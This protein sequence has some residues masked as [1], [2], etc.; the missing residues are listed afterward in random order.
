MV[1]DGIQPTAASYGNLFTACRKL[2]DVERASSLYRQACDSGVLPNDECHNIL[3][4]IYADAG[5]WVALG[6]SLGFRNFN[7]ISSC[8]YFCS[9]QDCS[10]L[11]IAPRSVSVLT[12]KVVSK[13]YSYALLLPPQWGKGF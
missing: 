12:R 2:G 4:N 9:G 1:E 5:R 11:N 8:L 10:S 3:I 6:L 13:N 7:E